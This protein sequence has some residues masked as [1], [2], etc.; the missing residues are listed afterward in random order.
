MTAKAIKK[1][2]AIK[3]I[4]VIMSVMTI[5]SSIDPQLDAN[6]VITQGD[7]K[8]NTIDPTTIRINAIAMPI[9]AP[10]Y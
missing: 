7:K 1:F 10:Y 9:S 8:W 2:I 5:M 3:T 6:G 4:P